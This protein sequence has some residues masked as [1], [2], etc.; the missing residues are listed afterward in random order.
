MQLRNI[1]SNLYMDYKVTPCSILNPNHV[2]I[3]QVIYTNLDTQENVY[4]MYKSDVYSKEDFEYNLARKYGNDKVFKNSSL[5]MIDSKS[6][7]NIIIDVPDAFFPVNSSNIR[8]VCDTTTGDYRLISKADAKKRSYKSYMHFICVTSREY[9]IIEEM[10]NIRVFTKVVNEIEF[11]RALN[12]EVLNDFPSEFFIWT[13]LITRLGFDIKFISMPKTA[14]THTELAY[15]IAKMFTLK[16][17]SDFRIKQIPLIMT[18]CND[19]LDFTTMSLNRI[20][21]YLPIIDYSSRSIQF[22]TIKETNPIY[23]E[24]LNQMPALSNNHAVIPVYEF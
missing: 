7:P 14:G 3:P 2:Y 18:Y 8:V 9:D 5:V 20:D 16:N 23:I 4:Y 21:K 19:S 12:I 15:K 13:N 10:P 17:F 1:E 24:A 6:L 11:R 22:R